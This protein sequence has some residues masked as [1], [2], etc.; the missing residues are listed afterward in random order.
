MRIE[1]AINEIRGPELR[2]R[3]ND[4]V[5]RRRHA[6]KS[7]DVVEISNAARALGSNSIRQSDLNSVS[8]VREARVEAVKQRVAEGYYDRPEVRVAIAQA[9]LDSGLVDGLREEAHQAKEAREEVK[10]LPD[11]RQDKVELAR[12]RVA[13]DFY[14][15]AGAR[16]AIATAVLENIVG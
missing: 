11:V 8:D 13:A 6:Q 16:S 2:E 3:R 10:N 1:N 14:D 9:V 5:R 12:R 15:S 4:E 7:G